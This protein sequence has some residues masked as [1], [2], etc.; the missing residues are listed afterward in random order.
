MISIH[1]IF[2]L[3]V[4]VF[5]GLALLVQSAPECGYIYDGSHPLVDIDRQLEIH[6]LRINWFGFNPNS[7]TTGSTTG[8]S[9]ISYQVAVISESQANREIKKSGNEAPLALRCRSSQGFSGKPNVYGFTSITPFYK[10]GRDHFEVDLYKTP[11]LNLTKGV[12]YYVILK[13]TQGGK[14]IYSNSNGVTVGIGKNNGS[15]DDD[16]FPAYK[17]GLI[18]MGIAIC[19][20]LVLLLLLIL[21]AKGKGEDKYTT[22]VHR[23]ENVDKL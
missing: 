9:G 23:N 15:S 18:A 13:I 12:R 8:S 4:L 7:G 1:Q 17:A 21:V 16:G 22:T 19:C 10:Y 2:V 5:L 14:T 11:Y 3:S 20:L 6:H